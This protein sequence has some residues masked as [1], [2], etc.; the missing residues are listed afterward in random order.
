MGLQSLRRVMAITAVL[1]ILLATLLI[2]GPTS[3]SPESPGTQATLTGVPQTTY[4]RLERTSLDYLYAAYCTL[5]ASSYSLDWGQINPDGSTAWSMHQNNPALDG[6]VQGVLFF[7]G[8]GDGE[9]LFITITAAGGSGNTTSRFDLYP[10]PT[11]MLNQCSVQTDASSPL[12]RDPRY[13]W[14]TAAG[15][16]CAFV[17]PNDPSVIP[18]LPTATA[19]PLPPTATPLPSPTVIPGPSQPY[20]FQVYVNAD[21]TGNWCYSDAPITANI[22]VSCDDRISSI[23]LKPGWSARVYRDSNQQGPSVCLNASDSNLADNTFDD[24]SPLNDAISS[25]IL[26]QQASCPTAERQPVYPFEVYTNSGYTGS[27]C[28][29]TTAERANIYISC[30]DQIS[31]LLLKP[32][33][34]VRVY[35]DSNQQGPSVCLNASDSNLTDTTFD[36]GSPLN[37]AISSFD[38]FAEPGC[39]AAQP[40]PVNQPRTTISHDQG[41]D[42]CNAPSVATMQAWRNQS[43]FR[44]VGIYIGGSMRGCPDQT[45]LSAQWVAQVAQQGW[46]F[47]PIW[48]GPQAPC[49]GYRNRISYDLAAARQQGQ[50]EARSAIA[51]ARDNGLIGAAGGQTIIYYDME[52]FSRDQSCRAA[53]TAFMGGW[54]SQLHAEGQLAGAYGSACQSSVADWSG[55]NPAP[56]AVWIASWFWNSGSGSYVPNVSLTGLGGGCGVPDNLWTNH[57]RLRQYSG[58]HTETWGNTSLNVDLN[59]ADGPVATLGS[60]AQL[61]EVPPSLATTTGETT[62]TTPTIT[63]MGMLSATE[64]WVVADQQL[65]WTSDAGA[66]WKTITPPT[67]TISAVHFYDPSHG[68]VAGAG[69][70]SDGAGGMIYRTTD[71][72]QQWEGI[73]P[74]VADVDGTP[75]PVSASSLFFLNPQT[76]WA[77]FKRPTSANF[78]E[79]ILLKT[80]DGGKTWRQKGLLSGTA[81]SFSSTQDGWAIGGSM[82]NQF[83]VTHDGGAQ[84]QALNVITQIANNEQI[85]YQLPRFSTAN[86]GVLPV[87]VSG[88]GSA[89]VEFF[90]THDA[91]QSWTLL[92]T[93]PLTTEVSPGADVPL[94]IIDAN[95]Q[96]VAGAQGTVLPPEPITMVTF[97]SATTGWALV[98]NGSCAGTACVTQSAIYQTSDGSAHWAALPLSAAQYR[99]YLPLLRR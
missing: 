56:D 22:H 46:S 50:D 44:F 8:V 27:Q 60:A 74:T 88:G 12:I 15:V 66:S 30:N 19:M 64:G 14:D 94:A 93:K 89:R 16:S 83:L 38:L 78:S 35:R 73:A 42:T 90:A 58:G 25:F 68:W 92:E 13:R 77:V 53:V 21:Y 6:C 75:L 34:S 61:A 67:S 17:D 37:D 80:S 18:L 47:V 79:S 39:P 28:Y 20:A 23:L 43:P 31:S 96:W 87:V 9:H 97:S 52:N 10:S 32:G 81:V 91:G 11:H 59:Q 72:G 41:F 45:Y 3:A 95:K 40:V 99:T 24:G 5:A 2:S 4:V 86:D 98:R 63:D 36:D 7:T 1:S 29:S 49:T 84:W 76:G 70:A 33:W 82:G 85:H 69:S 65:I 71:G 62:T 26:Y 54:T 57:Q 55:G 51:A 48:V